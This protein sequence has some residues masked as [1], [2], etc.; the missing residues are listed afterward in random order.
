M[1]P[2]TRPDPWRRSLPKVEAADGAAFAFPSVQAGG[3]NEVL[4]FGVIGF[5]GRGLAR[6]AREAARRPDRS[7]VRRRHAEH[8][9]ITL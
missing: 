9:G 4:N 2:A 8:R 7:R 3:A 5:G 1:N 6:V